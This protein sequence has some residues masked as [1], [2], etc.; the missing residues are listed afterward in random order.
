MALLIFPDWRRKVLIRAPVG[1]VCYEIVFT[2]KISAVQWRHVE[3][4]NY[5]ISSDLQNYTCIELWSEVGA[6]KSG[7]MIPG[8][9][10]VFI[11]LDTNMFANSATPFSHRIR[12]TMQRRSACDW[13]SA[14]LRAGD[15]DGRT[16][17]RLYSWDVQDLIWA[18][19]DDKQGRS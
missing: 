11:Y 12:R 13:R 10:K 18:R 1:P 6:C 4:A 2:V 8:R 14:G 5:G 16:T 9:R 15:N 7:I 17:S 19:R 3:A